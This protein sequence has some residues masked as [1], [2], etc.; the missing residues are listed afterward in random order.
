MN[1]YNDLKKTAREK[2][3]LF[4]KEWIYAKIKIPIT[5]INRT[6]LIE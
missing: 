5:L 1:S 3:K 6:Y 4:K 2:K